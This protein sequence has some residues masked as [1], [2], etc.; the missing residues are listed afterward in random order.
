LYQQALS[1]QSRNL[2][3]GA[4]GTMLAEHSRVD[5]VHGLELT[6][7]DEEDAAAQH[8]LEI[9]SGS[10]QDRLNVLQHLLGLCFD[11]WCERAGCGIDAGLTRHEDQ[12]IE[13]DPWRV[14]S[15]RR[16]KMA[17]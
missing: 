7:V 13:S 2:Y 11:V 15:D 12:P 8:V 9:G 14:R 4:R 16:G 3:R 10:A 6:H 1:R 17:C 5:G